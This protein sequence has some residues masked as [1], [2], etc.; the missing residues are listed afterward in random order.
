MTRRL[1]LLAALAAPV[2]V[3]PVLV[4]PALAQPAPPAVAPPGG[5]RE[6]LVVEG[7]RSV[8][9]RIL[10][11]PGATLH[12]APNGPGRPAPGFAAHYVYARQGEGD[13]AWL[14]VGPALDG[15]GEGWVRAERTLSWNHGL[16]ATFTNP[17]GRGRTVFLDTADRARDLLEGG[18]TT[19][20]RLRRSAAA[21]NAP[22]VVAMEPET[23][24][25]ITQRFYL[26]PILSSEEV[27]R[28]RGGPVRILE[29]VSAPA[30]PPAPQP[31]P[32]DALSRFRA[33]LTFVVDTT[34]SMQPYI[35]RTRE[36][37]TEFVTQL[38]RT[39]V[40]DNFRFG[41]VGF[42]D[43]QAATPQGFDYVARTF[44]RPD[45]N[46]APDAVL[47]A[48]R[49]LA[50]T[51]GANQGFDEDTVAGLREA[52]QETDWAPLVGRFVVLI[53]DAGAREASDALSSTGMGLGQ[54]R[55]L[56]D[57][58]EAKLFVIHVLTPEGRAAGNHPR[59]RRQYADLTAAGGVYLPV[60]DGAPEAFRET[61]SA[62]LRGIIEQVSRATGRP[63]AELMAGPRPTG[64][65]AARLAQQLDV[66]GEAMRLTYL[67]REGRAAAPD[68]VRS[69]VL[70]RDP[71]PP[72]RAALDVR[73]LLTRNQLS[74]LD[75]AL[76]RIVRAG[77]ATRMEPRE[78]FG[79]LQSALAL[80]ARQPDRIGRTNDLGG[81]L[82]EY[83]EDLPYQSNIMS[84]DSRTW[85]MMGASA[86]AQ[87]LNEIDAKRRLYLEF[88]RNT[89]LWVTLSGRRDAGE[90]VFPVPL[91]ALP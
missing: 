30:E 66:I 81:L 61:I 51:T 2:L 5:V 31:P 49:G 28:E 20:D 4:P 18:A 54:M 27:D 91:S 23:F 29:V 41:V 79:Q 67:G 45:F 35:D 68:A 38:G 46:A 57:E 37:M 86:Q 13:A 22:G 17:A 89:R 40:R 90:Q 56:A 48:M 11:R 15:R 12:A 55:A 33:G 62:L 3:P 21:G 69:Y 60:D 64:P 36:A 65:A 25:D 1:L 26:L 32:P 10:L 58:Q 85:E 42:R 73:V 7:R 63:A 43:S 78:F 84:L 72:G 50:A 6:P 75:G 39:A 82:A 14:E 59:A 44:A 77:R 53:T 16:V 88:N 19:A 24:V 74:D 52:L 47:G 9:Q 80:A 70:D 76:E 87:I 8:R 83:L 34:V 71:S